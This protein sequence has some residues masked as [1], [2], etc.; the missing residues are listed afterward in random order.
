M[1]RTGQNRTGQDGVPGAK[2]V[3]AIY[4]TWELTYI[5]TKCGLT[6]DGFIRILAVVS[7]QALGCYISSLTKYIQRRN[8]SIV[9][10][11]LSIYLLGLSCYYARHNNLCS[12]PVSDRTS[13]QRF[14][15][16]TDRTIHQPGTCNTLVEPFGNPRHWWLVRTIHQSAPRPIEA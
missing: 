1:S 10:F 9:E 15:P 3:H 8:V 2:P 5:S 14:E 6:N 11:S 4:P 16:F 7:C 13:H 12:V